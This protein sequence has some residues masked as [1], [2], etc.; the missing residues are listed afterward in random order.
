V[1][2]SDAITVEG[3][4]IEALPNTLYRVRLPNG[5]VVLAHLPARARR[6][7]VRLECGEKVI[8]EMTPFD[9]SQG[10]IQWKES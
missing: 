10:R 8:L 1:A 9:L 5:H 3:A 7:A 2:A 6:L 4:V